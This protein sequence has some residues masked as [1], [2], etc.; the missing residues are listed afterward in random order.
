MS[1]N[2]DV[3]AWID[4]M[5]QGDEAAA[6][7][8][9]ERYFTRLV[10]LADRRLP[11]HARRAFDEEDVALSAFGSLCRGVRA[12]KFPQLGDRENLWALLVVIT[13]RK[14]RARLRAEAAKK[15]GGGVLS[16][17][18]ALGQGENGI[19]QTVGHEPTP[20][21]AVEVAEQVEHL[22][23]RLPDDV[24]RQ[25]AIL[26]LEGFTNEQAARRLNCS[27]TTIER[28]LRLIRKVWSQDESD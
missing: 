23:T 26:K 19:A 10:E 1:F 16:G 8:L 13:A 28:R 5:R 2:E 27:Q 12:G 25:L 3:T 11:R 6:R 21:F 7:Q 9:W 22:L 18:S 24:S 17:E 20:E 15:R 4:G 14:A